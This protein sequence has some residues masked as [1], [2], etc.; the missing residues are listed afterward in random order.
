MDHLAAGH[1][2]VPDRFD[3]RKPVDQLHDPEETI[4]QIMLDMEPLLR[5]GE[6][7]HHPQSGPHQEDFPIPCAEAVAVIVKLLEYL[8][9]REE[10]LAFAE[11]G[12]YEGPLD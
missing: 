8:I 1:L 6:T 9:A 2:A 4:V 12:V 7:W 10:H 5:L 11:E 3:T